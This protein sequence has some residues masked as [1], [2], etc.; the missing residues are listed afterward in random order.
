MGLFDTIHLDPPLFCPNC[1]TPITEVQTRGFGDGMLT[2]NIGAVL[3]TYPVIKGIVKESHWCS[4]CHKAEKPGN[5]TI[6]LVIWHSVLVGVEQD[7]PKAEARLASVDRLDLIGWLEA[8]QREVARW[9]RR[10]CDLY[11]DVNSWRKHLTPKDPPPPDE[12]PE[13]AELR[14]RHQ[15]FDN[16]WPLSGEILDSPDPLAAILRKNPPLADEDDCEI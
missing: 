3:T 10:Y 12:T 8:R 15:F 6:F 11:R 16:P 2:Y 5:S 13:E 7:L 1:E 9:K 14:K 4:V